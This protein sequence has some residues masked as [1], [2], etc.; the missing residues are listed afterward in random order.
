MNI[1]KGVADLIRRTS[2]GQTGESTSG[3]QVEKFSAPS[4]KIRFRTTCL[5]ADVRFPFYGFGLGETK[6][7]YL[8]E[9]GDEAILC[10]LWGRYE[11]A[12]DKG[13]VRQLVELVEK[14]KL[15]FVFL[16]QFL[17]VYK[18]WE[19]V[20]SGQ[21]LDTASSAAP[22]G[23]YSSRFDDI[24]VGCSAGHPAEII[25]V[26]TEEVGQL[27]ALVTE[28]ITNSVQ[29]ITVSGASTSF[30]ITS[31][32]FPVLDALKIVTRS[33]HNC[34]VFGYYGGIQKLTTLMKGGGPF[35]WTG[36]LNG[37]SRSRWGGVRRG[38]TPFRFENMWLKEDGFKD[39]LKGWWQGFNYNGSY[40]F[41]LTEKLKALKI[42]LKEWNSEVFGRIEVNKRLALDKVSHWDI[43]EQLRVLN[44]WE[45]EAR[46]EAKEDFKKWVLMEEIS[47]RQKSRQT[48]LKE[49]DKNTRFFHKM[50]NSNRRK[51]CLKKIK[52]NG[53]WLSEEQEIQRGVV[54][55]FQSLLSDPGGWRPSVDNLEFDSIGVEEAARLELMFTVEEVFLALSELN[56]DKAPGP[57]GFTLAFWHF[58]WDFVKDEIM[59]LFKDFFERGKFVRSL[60]TT[61]LVLIPK[62]GGA[63]DLT[64]FRPISLVGSLYKLLAKV[65]ANRLKKVVGKVVSTTQNAFVEGRQ[66]LDAALIANEVIDSLMKR[67]ESGV[68][69]KLDL[70]KAYDRIN[71][72][73]LLSVMKKMGFGEKWAGW[74]RWCLSTASFSV[75][76][77]GSPTGFFRNT[78]G[79]RQGD[80]LSPYLFVL[81]MEALTSL[82]NRA[83]RGG[84]LSGCSIR[85]REGAEI[86]VSHLLFADDT[87][88]FCE[89]SQEQL[90]FLSWLLLWFEAISGLRI[91]L[92]KSEILPVGRVENAELLAAEL[93]CKV[94]SLP[95]TYLGLPL[96]ASHKS[97]MV[98]DGMEERMRKRLALW[99]R[100]FI[101]KGG[102]IT[103]IRSTLASIPT[104]LMSLMR[105]PK[106]V[107]LRLEKIQRDFLWG[108]GAL[109]KKPHLIKWGIVCSHKKKGG[110]GIRDLTILNR[111]LLCKWSWRFAVER[112]SYWKLIIGTK[113]GV[114]SGGWCTCGGREGYGVGLWKEISKEGLLLLNNVSFSV[115]DGKR[116]RF[117][118]DKWCGNT[119][120]CE[121]YPSLF[122]LAVSKDAKVADCWDSMG[123]VG[124]WNSRFLR[125]FND[126]EVEE[127]ESFLL[128]I[129]GKRLNADLE[130]RMVWK[131]TKDGNF[132]VKSCF[133]SLDHSSAVPFPW[134]II[135]SS[136]VPSKVGFFTWEAAWGKV[137]TQDQLKRRGWKLANRCPL[138][139][140]EEETINHILIHCPKAKVLWD[141]LFSLF[142]VNWVTPFS[143]RDTLLGW[144]APLEDKKRSK[145]MLV[146]SLYTL[147]R[148]Y[149]PF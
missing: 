40:S 133:N 147:G 59:G 119:P 15:L 52:V 122:D 4:P 84:Y 79:L 47:W 69:C 53:N 38:P 28:L 140:D 26:L 116:V 14:R 81:G 37:Q 55:A 137:L 149:A 19:P 56:G 34:R 87:L 124:G 141:L 95:S 45:L 64:D 73:F 85:G 41:I 107:K 80:P 25:L 98:W 58:C 109:E 131:E 23:E 5:D 99:K 146:Y 77:N 121:A 144:L 44:D 12:I 66:I 120:L 9:V 75:L 101:S 132:S 148:L 89:N 57:D 11:N 20:D 10:T 13:S 86:R 46:K 1:V 97:V 30:T 16:K 68:L 51:N 91:N 115:G 29:S 112:D 17:I 135:W 67:K 71:W 111:A 96:G 2:G 128:I 43:Q 114:G 61:F 6:L 88:V 142:G 76:I 139:C 118:K 127:V 100:Q 36:G 106:V 54:R 3:P 138:C 31:E 83:V 22:T 70:E 42:K 32:G 39:L 33:M 134:R 125:P 103:L 130:D 126:W 113:F 117:W 129:Q 93:G 74:I 94:G 21:F 92:N 145:V 108:G 90:A 62:K 102:R 24:L 18:N 65:L 60:N 8:N 63:E 27:T 110:L 105:M 104:Y 35:T 49:G 48:W 78:R 7:Y 123:E 82:I 143:V 50:A 72:D 136:F